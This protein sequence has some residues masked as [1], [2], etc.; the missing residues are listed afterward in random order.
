MTADGRPLEPVRVDYDFLG[1]RVEP[2][3]RQVELRFAP[4]SFR[5]GVIVSSIG[6][7]LLAGALLAVASDDPGRRFVAGTR[8]GSSATSGSPGRTSRRR[9]STTARRC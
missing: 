1:V 4:R 9:R 7:M 8:S 5:N 6:A 3:V 2:G